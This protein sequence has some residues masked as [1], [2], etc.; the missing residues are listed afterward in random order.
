M[1]FTVS[2]LSMLVMGVFQSHLALAQSQATKGDITVEA[3]GYGNSRDEAL[4]KAKREAIS[5]GIGT[6]LISETEVRNYMVQRNVVLA[7]TLGSVRNYK[8]LSEGWQDKIYHI[9]ISAVVSLADIRDDLV[10]RKILMQ[11]MDSPRMMV[12]I[13]EADGQGAQVAI[14]DYLEAK[15]VELVDPAQAEAL[16][17]KDAASIRKA[18]EGDPVAAAKLGAACGAEYIITGKVKKSVSQTEL[19]K[20]TGL[21]SGHATLTAWVVNA[22]NARIIASGMATAAAVHISG[23]TAMSEAA[24]KAARKL[25]DKQ[26]FHKIIASFEDTV[27]NGLNI[28]VTVENI[29]DF[30]TEEAVTA[31]IR[32]LDVTAVHKR[33]FVGGLLKLSVVTPGTVGGFVR[34]LDGKEI[35]GRKLAAIA[36]VGNR[37]V[38]TLR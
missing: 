17:G 23:Q 25:M 20:E 38:L 35:N 6:L 2:L 3:Q 21:W 34:A 9:K 1:R 19:L 28:D 13:H 12:M 18:T 31:F 7:Q 37:V 24:A 30:A 32:S 29:P 10:A 11:S 36:E 4:L 16:A 27:N 22:S 33:A 14:D 15:K 5:S 8:I 26:L